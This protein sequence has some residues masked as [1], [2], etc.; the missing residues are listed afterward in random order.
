MYFILCVLTVTCI[1]ATEQMQVA[2]RQE[3]GVMESSYADFRA[4]ENVS[5][6]PVLVL[7]ACLTLGAW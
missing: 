4:Q 6:N 3:G 1:G 5:G 7:S 2:L